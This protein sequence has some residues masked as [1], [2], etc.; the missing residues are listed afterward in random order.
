VTEFAYSRLGVNPHYSIFGGL[1][2]AGA[3]FIHGTEF[4]AWKPAFA[5]AAPSLMRLAKRYAAKAV[6]FANGSR[7]ISS[8]PWLRR[9]MALILSPSPVGI[10]ECRLSQALV[11]TEH[12]HGLPPSDPSPYRQ[13]KRV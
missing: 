4:E 8:T 5:E 13:Q 12:L 6:I 7:I 3:D 2:D 9:T 1:A 11:R 10:D